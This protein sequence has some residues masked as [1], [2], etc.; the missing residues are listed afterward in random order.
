MKEY[1][2][3]VDDCGNVCWYNTSGFLDRENG[4]ACEYTDGYKAW[5][6]NGKL[7]RENDLPAQKWPSGAKRWWINGLAHRVNGPA[8]L[9]SDGKETYYLNGICLSKEAHAR[10][11]K[12]RDGEIIEEYGRKYRLVEIKD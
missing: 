7:H 11:T 10:Q 12:S 3:I 9:Y 1:K 8:Y 4:P 5:Y 6:K 2:V